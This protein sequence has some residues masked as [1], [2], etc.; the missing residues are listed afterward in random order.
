[1]RQN[2]RGFHSY[3]VFILFLLMGV[4]V[5]TSLNRADEEYTR[6]QFIADMEADRVAEVV[7]R[8]NSEV[9][10]GYLEVELKSGTD[11]KLYVTDIGEAE[12]LARGYGFDPA[13][14]DVPREGWVLTTLV[15]M[16]IVLAVGIFLFMMINAQNA[17]GGNWTGTAAAPG[18]AISTATW[19]RRWASI[20]PQSAGPTSPLS[21]S[22]ITAPTAIPAVSLSPGRTGQPSPYLALPSTSPPTTALSRTTG[23]PSTTA[24][25]C[26]GRRYSSTSTA[27]TAASAA[28]WPGPLKSLTGISCAPAPMPSR[29]I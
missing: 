25:W 2:N 12:A 8:P 26:A 28:I 11:M 6:E 10:T 18:R 21:R 22:A 17:A 5:L 7:V 14:K 4:A 23:T 15:P 3:F 19:P 20:P 9:P 13:V 27:S 16:L 29:C 1:M 24:T